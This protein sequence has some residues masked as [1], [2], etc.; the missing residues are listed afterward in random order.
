MLEPG[1]YYIS[2]SSGR[3]TEENCWLYAI[4]LPSHTLHSKLKMIYSNGTQP[5]PI[6]GRFKVTTNSTDGTIRL[7][8]EYSPKC[9]FWY[10]NFSCENSETVQANDKNGLF[11]FV[12]TTCNVTDVEED[13]QCYV[14]R[15]IK[16]DKFARIAPDFPLNNS[17][18][19]STEATKF[20]FEPID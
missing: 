14:L 9:A 12:P 10:A 15:N 5:D 1:D 4:E 18:V 19:I 7:F 2:I 20:L 11:Q 17:T 3:C 8:S 16:E 6:S 13:G